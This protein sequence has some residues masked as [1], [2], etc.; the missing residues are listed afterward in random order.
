MSLLHIDMA[1]VV[2][3][4]YLFYIVNIMTADDLVTQGARAAATM[5]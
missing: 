2:E 4:T 3:T 5:I 1:Q